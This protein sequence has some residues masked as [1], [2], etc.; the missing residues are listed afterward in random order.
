MTDSISRRAILAFESSCDETAIALVEEGGRVVFQ[1]LATQIEIHRRY[2]GVVPEVASRA[3]FSVMDELLGKSL[4]EL[5]N[6][7]GQLVG[8][9]ATKGPGLIGPLI[10]GSACAEGLAVSKKIP[11]TGVHH[12]RGHLASVLLD[13]TL[14]GSTLRERAD[15]LFPAWVVLASGGH[16][17]VMAVEKDLSCR[18]LAETAD[19]AAGE[20][21]DKSAKLMGLPY[22]GGPEIERMAKLVA[23][24]LDLARAQAFSLELPRP[25]SE[26]GFSFSGLK[27]AIRLK[28]QKFP[29]R[30]QD[31]AFAWAVQD[32]IC[33]SLVA[34][35]KRAH[36]K[37]SATFSSKT[38]LFCG[39]VAANA[40][41]RTR[42]EAWAIKE[43]V[44]LRVPPLKYCT[45]NAAMI[46]ASAWVQAPELALSSCEARIAL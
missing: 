31:P 4:V 24:D 43:R 12:L 18:I 45:D 28:L 8:I 26:E 39:G 10:V 30:V 27:T 38:W 46:A 6:W 36:K 14:E 20:C 3:H 40:A 15:K 21:F 35:M 2:G 37:H 1:H 22:P 32:A 41:L 23:S 25:R 29:E 16:T 34:G 17:Q 13:E 5:E 9:A 33:A 7:K 11:F 19:D 42:L 44:G